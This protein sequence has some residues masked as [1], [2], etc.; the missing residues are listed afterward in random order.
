MLELRGVTKKFSVNTVVDHVT[1]SVRPGEIQGYLGPNGAGKTTT[2]KMLAGLLVP[3]SGEIFYDGKPIK[4]DLAAFKKRLGYVPE[5]SELY[6]QLA[7]YD[8]LL[9]VGRLRGIPEASLRTRILEFLRIFDLESDQYAALGSF[10]K[11]MRQKVLLTA[12][13][14]HDPD[15]LLLD[16]P[17]SGL[18]VATGLVIRDLVRRLAAEGKM[19]LYSSHVLEVTEKVC[20]RVIIL[21]RGRIVADDSVANLRNLMHLPSLAEIFNE[22]VVH[23]D[24][25]LAA[26]RLVE[27]MK[28]RA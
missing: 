6:P 15:I 11:G 18:D 3:S 21:H 19:I 2:I 22:L 26:G 16:E 25:D 12:A 24:P 4:H 9:L 20:S 8:Y 7:A 23:E 1:F 10:S 13:L 5:Q 28:G 17:L 27:A 14:L